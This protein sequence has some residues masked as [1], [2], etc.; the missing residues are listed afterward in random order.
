[1]V[2]FLTLLPLRGVDFKVILTHLIGLAGM[3]RG[4]SGRENV[5]RRVV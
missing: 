3:N 5:N 4:P 2:K 1:M